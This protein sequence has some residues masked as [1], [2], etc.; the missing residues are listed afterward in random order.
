VRLEEWLEFCG[1]LFDETV[2]EADLGALGSS[3]LDL[4][5]VSND[6]VTD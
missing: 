1:A 3:E 6:D 2:V 5:Y 4:N